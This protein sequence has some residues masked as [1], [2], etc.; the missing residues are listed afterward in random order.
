MNIAKNIITI[1]IIFIF[2]NLGYEFLKLTGICSS[3]EGMTNPKKLANLQKEKNKEAAE[4]ALKKEKQEQ[5]MHKQVSGSECPSECISPIYSGI[6]GNCGTKIYGS[7]IEGYYRICP[8]SCEDLSCQEDDSRCAKCPKKDQRVPTN[9]DGYELKPPAKRDGK[10]GHNKH[11][12]DKHPHDK[13][14]HDKHPHDK[15]PHDKHPHDKH[16]H[17]KHP[18]DGHDEHQKYKKFIP[19]NLDVPLSR[20]KYEE[21]GK[22]FIKDQAKSKG[23][24]PVPI[25]DHEAE[26]LGKMV[27]R[28]YAAEMEQKHANSPKAKDEVLSREI[29]LLNKVSTIF[30][31]ESDHHKGKG[32]KHNSVTNQASDVPQCG[33]KIYRQTRT[34]NLYGYVPPNSND[35]KREEGSKL[36]GSP[37][38]GSPT[39]YDLANATEHCQQDRA[40]GGVNFNS[41]TGE[42]RLMHVHSHLIHD[43]KTAHYTAFVKKKHSRPV[44]PNKRDGKKGHAH[45]EHHKGNPDPYQPV[46]GIGFSGSKCVNGKLRN[47]NLMPRPYNS[48]MDLF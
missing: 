25:H 11:P 37:I 41:T 30:K 9:K 6:T 32:K 33:S 14:H 28:V 19:S 34:N 26:I 47:P 10:D 16:P 43:K 7:E 17:V 38:H 44:N 20:Q 15:H 12:H 5:Q 22:D 2:V 3:N 40:C 8:F 4:F 27:W 42:Y 39:Y 13:H 29:Q 35:I 31:S 36:G 48:L 1:I 18:H 23:V 21:I 45:G 46:T 24:S